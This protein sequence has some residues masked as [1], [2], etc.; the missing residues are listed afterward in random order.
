ME[1]KNTRVRI[2]NDYSRKS[3]YFAFMHSL[4]NIL[5]ILKQHKPELQRK[6]YKITTP[7]SYAQ[8]LFMW[9]VMTVSY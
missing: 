1:Y 6:C 3:I 7:H 9:L 4:Q 2:Q 5:Q 8:K